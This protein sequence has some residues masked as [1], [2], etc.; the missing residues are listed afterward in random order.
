MQSHRLSLVLCMA[1][2]GATAP[3]LALAADDGQKAFS[4]ACSSCHTAKIRPL[5]N[6]QLTQEQW[7]QAIN[8][9]VEL[10]AE[11]P[12]DK[13]PTL[14]DYLAR[15]HGPAGTDTSNK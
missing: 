6:K 8:R 12:K 11:I 14:L 1:S 2:F 5:D 4:E 7:K 10:G 9:M 15:T 3:G 13:I